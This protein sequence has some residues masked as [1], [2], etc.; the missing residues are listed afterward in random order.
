M[1]CAREGDTIWGSG[2]NAKMPPGLHTFRALDVR[3]VRGPLT[4]DFLV[5]LGI[6][7]PEVFGDPALLLP[8]L[9]KNL[10]QWATNK[11]YDV[12]IIPNFNDYHKYEGVAGVMNPRMPLSKCLRRIAQSRFVIS[13]SLHGLVVAE[14]LRIPARLLRSESEHEFK[15]ADYY[16]GTGRTD[17]DV[18]E[19][20]KDAERLGGEKPLEW[21]SS[22]LRASFPY[23]LWA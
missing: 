12:T 18:A 23:D 21:D 9:D 4:R 11:I 8:E 19:S 13:S 22:S 2:V 14:S 5:N 17:F 15:Y 1:H 20:V 16:L 10:R 7:V 3:A 6:R